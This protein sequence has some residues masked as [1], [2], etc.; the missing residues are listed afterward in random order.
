MGQKMEKGRAVLEMAYSALDPATERF[1]FFHC[2]DRPSSSSPIPL[3]SVVLV[4]TK[5][6]KVEERK[7]FLSGDVQSIDAQNLHAEA[8]GEFTC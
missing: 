7:L 6:E 4:E 1:S 2:P 5:V 8:T 3:G